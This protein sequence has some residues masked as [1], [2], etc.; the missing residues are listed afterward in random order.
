MSYFLKKCTKKGRVYLSIV[1]GYHDPVKGYTVQETYKS[2]GTGEQLI[3]EGITDPEKYCKELVN[4]LNYKL[5]ENKN[6]QVTDKAPFKFLGNFL[7]NGILEKL[8][9]K[10]IIDIISLNKNF[11][12]NLYDVL[13]ALIFSRILKPCSKY[14]TFHDVIPY[15]NRDYKFSYDQ[16]LSGLGFLGDNYEGIVEIFTK[17]TAEKYKLNTSISYF[18]CTNFYF[19]IDKEDEFRKKGPSKENRALPLLGMGLLLDG[20][21]IPIGLKL[22]P[23]NQSEKPKIREIIEELKQKNH[24]KNKI[25]QVADK[26]L[27]CARN[28]FEARINNNGYIFSKSCKTLPET[29][30]K[31][32]FNPNDYKPITNK[33][34]D[35]LYYIKDCID[36]YI[37]AFDNDNGEKISFKILEK[38]VVTFNPTLA[39]KQLLE[40]QKLEDKARQL[41]LSK[42]A[43]EEYGECSKYV[44]FKGKDGAKANVNLNEKKLK[45]DKELCG[46]NLIVTSEKNLTNHEI[47]KIYHNLW[48]IEESFRMMKSELN[49]RP[50]FLQ[51]QS[52]VYG[53]FLVC[54]LC[55]LL[56]RILQIHELHDEE[57]YQEIF[58]FF[59]DFQV[60]NSNNKFV[61]LLTKSD[62][63]DK[64]CKITK[65]PI[66]SRLFTAK[67]YEKISNFKFR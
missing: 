60:V 8:N 66:S 63:L 17:L 59:R 2:F 46:Y 56:I 42:A 16:L 31:W 65:L 7:I 29:E 14:Q 11:R 6:E 52:T 39:K 13:C 5:K 40:I 37:Y 25:V 61:N 20:N 33:N 4:E 35:V 19:E 50:V 62:F 67:Q 49:A 43:K 9:A 51:K 12:F 55:T 57:S 41:C 10:E 34:G 1:N 64:I 23:G 21:Q 32:I 3:K 30:K 18:D 53:H 48:R 22:F 45:Q 27:N 15:L 58:K 24:L 38:R 44:T 28:I 47:Y 36:E 54:Y 26:G